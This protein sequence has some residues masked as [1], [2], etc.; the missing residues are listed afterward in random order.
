MPEVPQNPETTTVI[1]SFHQNWCA[2]ANVINS[3]GSACQG[4]QVQSGTMIR[5]KD[6]GNVTVP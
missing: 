1:D 4:G 2:G 5:Y 3:W 6:H